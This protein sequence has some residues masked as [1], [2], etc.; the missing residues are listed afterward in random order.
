MNI[1]NRKYIR[2]ASSFLHFLSLKIFYP[3]NVLDL[4]SLSPATKNVVIIYN[5]LNT[6][7]HDNFQL[8]IEDNYIS[9][10]IFNTVTLPNAVII[11]NNISV[12]EYVTQYNTVNILITIICG[13]S[14][15]EVDI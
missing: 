11:S 9:I 2:E 4:Y 14:S 3:L 10:I 8:S 13:E 15:I 7:T 12:S 5:F 1:Y 6:F